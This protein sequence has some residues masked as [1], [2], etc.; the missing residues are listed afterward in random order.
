MEWDKDAEQAVSTVPFF[1]RT[2]V[3]KRVEAEARQAGAARVTMEHV[4]AC[5]QR[6]QHHQENEVQGF[7][8]ESCFSPSGCP[9]R[10]DTGENLSKRLESL[11]RAH[12][13][14]E[15]MQ[16]RVSGPLKLH[17]EF[18]VT[19]ADCPNG[20]SRPQ[21]VDIGLISA[22]L[23]AHSESPCSECGACLDA[24]REKAITLAGPRNPD[25]S[26]TGRAAW[27]AANAPVPARPAPSPKGSQATAFCWAAS[28]AATRSLAGNFP[29]SFP[30][31]PPWP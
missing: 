27:P 17:H 10:I 12:N 2:P 28:W 13:L 20:C 1:V 5:K 19:L 24:C 7:T 3:K 29:E 4:T 31:K 6:Y 9:N 21:I 26:S 30:R 8:V 22:A 11:L 23:P 16:G 14:K 15:F 18:R 25:R